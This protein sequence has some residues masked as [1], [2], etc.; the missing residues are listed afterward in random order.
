MARVAR[1]V[2]NDLKSSLFGRDCIIGFCK[3]SKALYSRTLRV[4]AT[5]ESLEDT[6]CSL[7]VIS[8]FKECESTPAKRFPSQ[9]NS[10][11]FVKY[12]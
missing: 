1:E 3:T 4:Q 8:A 2:N 7:G 11:K 10:L 9:Q 5:T 12:P 6:S